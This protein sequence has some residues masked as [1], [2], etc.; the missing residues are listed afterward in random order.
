[1][2]HLQGVWSPLRAFTKYEPST[3]SFHIYF[4]ISEEPKCP[5]KRFYFASGCGRGNETP[6]I[7]FPPRG[8]LKYHSPDPRSRQPQHFKINAL[9]DLFGFFK[10]G[11]NKK[12][13]TLVLW[14]ALS[15]FMEK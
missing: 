4:K 7:F 5:R 8:K 10:K 11:I 1:M 9:G 14:I 6:N 13:N 15:M 2:L 12:A 3:I